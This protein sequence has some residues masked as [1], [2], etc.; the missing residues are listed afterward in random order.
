MFTKRMLI[1]EVTL[2]RDGIILPVLL[3][4]PG[5]GCSTAFLG[6][7]SRCIRIRS[8]TNVLRPVNKRLMPLFLR[9]IIGIITKSTLYTQSFYKRKLLF[10]RNGAEYIVCVLTKITFRVGYAEWCIA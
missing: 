5:I 7:K 6:R 4:Q 1:I 8:G 10:H 9:I 2:Q 3:V